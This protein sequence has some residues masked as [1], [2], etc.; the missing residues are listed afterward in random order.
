[1]Y[2]YLPEHVSDFTVNRSFVFDVTYFYLKLP[3]QIANTFDT[4]RV[5]QFISK[6]VSDRKKRI[7]ESESNEIK[8]IPALKSV[9]MQSN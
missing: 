4:E 8:L 5:K 7:Y 1:M 2:S 6:V 9:I 3:T